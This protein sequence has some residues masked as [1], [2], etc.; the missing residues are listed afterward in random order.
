MKQALLLLTAVIFIV[1]GC[2]EDT[3]FNTTTELE[4]TW[5]GTYTVR[6]DIGSSNPKVS[7]MKPVRIALIFHW[8]TFMKL[9]YALCCVYRMEQVLC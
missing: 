5:A 8:I 2:A 4:G 3:V 7:C 6:T 9:I 1:A